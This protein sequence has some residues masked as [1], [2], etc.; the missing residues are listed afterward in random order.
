MDEKLREV[1]DELAVVINE[2]KVVAEIWI[3][4]FVYSVKTKFTYKKIIECGSIS[5]HT[6]LIP[7]T[8]GD[9]RY[10]WQI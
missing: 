10:K 4:E 8:C 2:F 3:V 9:W 1:R 7:H 5:L 6:Y